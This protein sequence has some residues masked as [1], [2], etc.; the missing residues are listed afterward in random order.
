MQRSPITNPLFFKAFLKCYKTQ[1]F[2][3][4]FLFY[5]FFF[6]P[7]PPP[8]PRSPLVGELKASILRSRMRHLARFEPLDRRTERRSKIPPR[9]RLL[10]LLFFLPSFLPSL[11]LFFGNSRESRIGHLLIRSGNNL[12]LQSCEKTFGCA[13]F[14]GFW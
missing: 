10:R 8:N 13:F 3:F 7:P 12:Q 1:A 4:F 14:W 9:L 11:V 5:L 2:G 6:Y